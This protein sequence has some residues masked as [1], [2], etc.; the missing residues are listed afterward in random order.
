[1]SFQSASIKV[2]GPDISNYL[3]EP[4]MS[5]ICQMNMN[6]PGCGFYSP[7]IFILCVNI[8]KPQVSP[9]SVRCS[10]EK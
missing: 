3:S 4:H 9:V 2:N 5:D 8:L 10:L 6:W 1:M 7:T